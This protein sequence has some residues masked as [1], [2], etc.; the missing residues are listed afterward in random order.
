MIMNTFVAGRVTNACVAFQ[1]HLFIFYLNEPFSLSNFLSLTSH[2]LHLFHVLPIFQDVTG[3]KDRESQDLKSSGAHHRQGCAGDATSGLAGGKAVASM[4]KSMNKGEMYDVVSKLKEIADSNPD[5]ARK[6]LTQHPQMPEAILYCMS[7]LDIIKTPV[8]ALGTLPASQSA[9]LPPPPV[10]TAAPVVKPSDPRARPSTALPTPAVS[11][12]P[13]P[14][15]AMPSDP[16][17]RPADPRATRDPRSAVSGGGV[18]NFPPPPMM[19]PP[20]AM[21]PPPMQQ[22][23]ISAVAGLDPSLVQQV[24]ALTPAQISQ[25]P[26]DKQQSILA[27]RQQ[28]T[29]GVRH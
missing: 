20:P 23:S 6:L 28:I 11:Q 15:I 14:S 3:K 10:S 9:A 12:P 4:L 17:A 18:P 26:P 16:R 29:S 21:P 8:N 25:L 1:F 19:Q 24:M 2:L 22:Q 7:E 13:P 27:L 5:E